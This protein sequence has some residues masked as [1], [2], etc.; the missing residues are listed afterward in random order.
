MHV[1]S[2]IE[3]L[4]GFI[5]A[6]RAGRRVAFVP[7]MGALHAGHGACVEAAREDAD[8]LVAASIFVNPAQFGAGEDLHAY[9]RTLDSDAARLAEWGC[10][11]LFTPSVAT[12]YP[13]PQTVWVEPGP[14]AGPL[15]GPFRPGHFR[16][17]ATVVAKLFG[18]VRPDVA[19]FGAKDA[20]Q[21]LIV[22]TMARQL[23]DA[24]A[25][26]LVRTV[27]ES[28]GLAMS[29]RNAYL[30]ADE[31]ARAA[32]IHAALVL[33][34]AALAAGERGARAVESTARETLRRA[35]IERIDYADVLR[36]EDLSPLERLDGRVILAIAAWVGTTRLIDNRVFDVGAH[37]VICDAPLF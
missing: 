24:V 20:Q 32:S 31:R 11:V 33:A 4:Q 9:P 22:R 36:A 3:P 37:G 21:A 12:M 34:G 15:C 26:R 30:S 23:C 6:H 28:D 35:G 5:A 2:E 17:V 25:I 19:V 13:E 18:I 8:A 16:G 7:T 14:L 29:S 1:F 27:R 10:D